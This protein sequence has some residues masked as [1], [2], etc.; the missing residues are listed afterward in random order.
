MADKDD[1]NTGDAAPADAA[2]SDPYF[3]VDS[4]A[5]PEHGGDDHGLLS[6]SESVFEPH[7]IQ[8]HCDQILCLCV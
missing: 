6:W 1:G 7:C 8:C 3:D 5:T 2:T 4:P